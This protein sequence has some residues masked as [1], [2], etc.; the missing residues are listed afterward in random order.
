M[1]DD[2]G[3]YTGWSGLEATAVPVF[4]VVVISTGIEAIA[5][6]AAGSAGTADIALGLALA[7]PIMATAIP[8]MA[9]GTVIRTIRTWWWQTPL[10]RPG[11]EDPTADPVEYMVL[12][13][14]N[15]RGAA[16][17]NTAHSI[18]TRV[19]IWPILDVIAVAVRNSG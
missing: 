15:G 14:A 10:I 16:R 5:G 3:A 13:H 2:S 1:R 12:A 9:T 18:G 19:D 7:I 8:I 6:T 17:A 11:T 4:S